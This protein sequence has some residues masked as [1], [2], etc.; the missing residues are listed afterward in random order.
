MLSYNNLHA[1]QVKTSRFIVDKKRTFICLGM[2]LGKSVSTLTAIS[3]LVDS[4]SMKRGL[5]IAPLRVCNTVWKQEAQKWSHLTGLKINIA[6]GTPKQRLS[7]LLLPSDLVIINR[8]NVVWLV[9]HYCKLPNGKFD[10]SKWP[11]EGLFIDESS[12]F[13]SPTS[14]RFKALKRVSGISEFVVLLTGT[15]APNGLMDL[16][17]QT[18]LIDNGQALGRNITAYRQRYFDTDYMGYT[19]IPKD[20]AKATVEELIL[21]HTLSMSAEDYLDMPARIDINVEVELPTKTMQAYIDFSKNL[22]LEWKQSEF[23]ALSAGVLANKLL[24]F[25]NGALYTDTAKNFELIHDAKID[26]LM[27]IVSDNAGEN[28]LLAYNFKSDLARI[29]EKFPDAVILSK[30]GS[31]I[32]DW[33]AG[34]IKMLVAH[35]ASAGHGLNL[36]GGAATMV[37]FGL[38]WSL[39]LYQQF[40]ARLHRQGQTRPVRVFHI[41]SKGTIDERVMSVLG[42]KDA[43]Q[44]SLLN[45]LKNKH[46]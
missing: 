25:S 36:Q 31:E 30:D 18:F 7:A 23:E 12:S 44:S 37:W 35:P 13:K 22:Y 46:N 27:D 43:V 3:E 15:P 8:E 5:I 45:T 1:Y 32:D 14:A 17:S 24:Q 21:P 34:K 11:F 40:C 26:A 9:N 41:I 39:E 6:T 16:W 20:W 38:N 2:G 29:K 19:Y 10:Y 4:F 28:I 33:N 42:D